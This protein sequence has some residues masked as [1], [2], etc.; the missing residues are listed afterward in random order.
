MKESCIDVVS[1]SAMTADAT[2]VVLSSTERFRFRF[3]PMLVDN[4]NNPEQSVR[5]KLLLE[6]KSKNEKYFPTDSV[7]PCEKVTRGSAKNGDWVEIELHSEETYNLFMGLKKLYDLSGC[8]N[9]I[10]FGSARFAQIDS[11]FSSFLEV[12]QNDPSAARMIG[13]PQN[14][15]LIKILLQLITQTSSHESLKNS[16]SSLANENLQALTTSASLEGLKR[17][18][19]LMRE[20][21]DNGK[22]EFWQQ[23]VFNENQ[24]VLAQIFSCPCTIY[25]Q[26]A[27]VGGKS[28]DNKGGNVCDFIYRNKMTQNVALIEIKTPCTEIV[29]KPYRETYSMS[30]DM[31]G[32]VNQ[33]LNYRDELQKNFSTLTRDLEEA[34]TVRAFSP[35]CVV[36]IG[37]ISTLNAKQQKAFELY[38]SSFNN[39][40]IITFD[41]LHQKIC[42]LMSVFKEDSPRPVDSLMDEFSIIDEDY[43]I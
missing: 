22:E 8:M 3:M 32:A 36:V 19:A 40:T 13:E 20:N 31:S 30:L 27:F 17:V 11:S 5:G 2:P 10:P 43:P 15:E 4:Q 29:G 25:A 28:L 42:D 41:E 39:L 37:K 9:G 35:K 23:K 6:R 21:L 16:L 34:D 1:R 38:R 7:A 33:V 12:I 18:E 14:F 26:K 24:W